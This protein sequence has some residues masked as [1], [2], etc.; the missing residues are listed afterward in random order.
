MDQQGPPI[1]GGEIKDA[2]GSASQTM[3]DNRYRDIARQLGHR[4]Q[5]KEGRR[6]VIGSHRDVTAD[7]PGSASGARDRRGAPAASGLGIQALRPVKRPT[8]F[9]L[10]INLKT[11]RTLGLDVPTTL[12]AQANEVIE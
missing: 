1:V 6:R 5:V 9:Q 4:S 7:P 2:A 10:V 12:L 8:K 3:R 11:A